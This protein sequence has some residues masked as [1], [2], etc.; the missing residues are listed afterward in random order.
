MTLFLIAPLIFSGYI[1]CH[2]HKFEHLKLEKRHGQYLYL[3]F[4][5]WGLFFFFISSTIVLSFYHFHSGKFSFSGKTYD[6]IFLKI[7]EE[8]LRPFK[9][10]SNSVTSL[11]LLIYISIVSSL[12][13]IAS[14]SAYN[15]SLKI[16]FKNM[17]NLVLIGRLINKDAS[18][19]MLF[20]AAIERRN[21]LITLDTTKV[22]VGRLLTFE[23]NS[24]DSPDFH[25]NILIAPLLSGY[26]GESDQKVTFTTTYNPEAN[27]NY[28]ISIKKET[29]VTIS[30][31]DIDS[32]HTMQHSNQ[33]H[34]IN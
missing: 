1:Y 22:Y 31:F 2:F 3:T 11:S 6:F 9:T 14:A 18:K 27:I 25:E 33:S 15:F 8:S 29:I 17:A 23:L 12:L 20:D 26:R 19:I 34:I 13:A 28:S 30:H 4:F 7:T 32:Y 16:R 21:I 10:D 24:A 5:A